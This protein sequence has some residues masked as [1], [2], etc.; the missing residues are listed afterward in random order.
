MKNTKTV[1]FPRYISAVITG[2]LFGIMIT[3]SYFRDELGMLFPAWSAGDLTLIFSLHNAVVCI[4]LLVAGILLK[5]ISHR[6]MLFIS[7][8]M[9]LIGFGSF[10]FLPVDNPETAYILAFV[11]FTIIS[12]SSVGI[13]ISAGYSLYSQW[14]PDHPGKLMGAMA[15]ACSISPLFAGAACS[16]LIP[17]V[18]VLQAI[19]WIGIVMAALIYATLPFAS[20]PGPNDKLP[21]PLVRPDNLDMEDIPPIKM[22]RMP[23]FWLLMVF[24]AVVRTSGLIIIDFGGSIAIYFGTTALVGL[25]FSPASGLANVIGGI[26]IDKLSTS[27]VMFIGGGTLVLSAILLLAG[28][29]LDSRFLA[30]AGLITGGLSY[31]CCLVYNSSSVRNLFGPKYYA[32]NLSYAQASILLA[33]GGGY[34]AGRLLDAQ[35]GSYMGVFFLIL[36]FALISVACGAG[37]GVFLK[38]KRG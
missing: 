14:A 18:G 2:A 1:R 15:L 27:R 11:F 13:S 24:N 23:S 31:G 17:V 32:Q 37:M 38:R 3:W 34:L 12:A 6:V 28:N 5:R 20:P 36:V 16:R 4:A 7:G 30:I 10:P 26:L 8:T 19:R 22:L 29:S 25:L 9:M 35:G 33:A 21:P